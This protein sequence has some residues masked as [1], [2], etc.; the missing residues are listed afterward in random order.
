MTEKLLKKKAKEQNLKEQRI[1][2]AKMSKVLPNERLK[3]W[4]V[5]DRI[6][7]QYY[8]LLLDRQKDIE[9][10]TQLHTQNDELRNLLNQYLKVNH[11]LLV[12]PTDQLNVNFLE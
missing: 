3:M 10:T 11:N 12:P 1:Y 2:R 6:S 8:R 4:K 5:L 9:Q 7:S